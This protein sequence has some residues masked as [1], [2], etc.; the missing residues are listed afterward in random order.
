M[1]DYYWICHRCH[2]QFDTAIR[3]DSDE[4]EYNA[5]PFCRSVNVKQRWT[6]DG[7]DETFDTESEAFIVEINFRSDLP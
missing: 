2:E 4:G 6:V 1:V 3:V 5:C 7:I